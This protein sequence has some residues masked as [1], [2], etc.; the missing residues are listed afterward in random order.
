MFKL[1]NGGVCRVKRNTAPLVMIAHN[2]LAKVAVFKKTI[3]AILL[4]VA[5][6]LALKAQSAQLI[7]NARLGVYSQFPGIGGVT[8]YNKIGH[9]IGVSSWSHTS[10]SPD[11]IT[12]TT[13]NTEALQVGK[14]V[15]VTT[16][17]K[18][19]RNAPHVVYS[20]TNNASFS[21]YL[22][23]NTQGLNPGAITV[24]EYTPGGI[25]G[26]GGTGDAMD[27]FN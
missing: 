9:P 13:T 14:L 8:R 2:K 24:Y 22:E 12:C 1:K 26:W 19:L 18:S 16:G 10:G 15:V 7:T 4:S 11:Y 5:E 27:G 3:T 6:A 20:V 25:T 17:D 23:D 21:F